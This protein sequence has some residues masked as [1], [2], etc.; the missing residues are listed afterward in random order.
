MTHRFYPDDVL[1]PCR[2]SG[3][4][5]RAV[6]TQAVDAGVYRGHWPGF[7][8][9]EVHP[10]GTGTR[11]KRPS[12]IVCSRGAWSAKRHWVTADGRN[13]VTFR[14]TPGQAEDAPENGG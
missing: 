1:E 4:S 10:D 5:L 3:S 2:R 7:E 9:R 13:V 8:P 12:I 14:L 6:T 11:K